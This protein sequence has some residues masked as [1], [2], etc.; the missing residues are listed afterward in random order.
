MKGEAETGPSKVPV[1]N[2]LAVLPGQGD[3]A[4]E[5]VVVGAHYDHV[6]MGGVGSL[7]PGTIAVHNGADDNG[8]GRSRFW[9]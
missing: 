9:R 6:G 4:S 5:Y 1:R 2:V 3:L 7:A 8:R